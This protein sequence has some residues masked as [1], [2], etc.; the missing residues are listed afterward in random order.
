MIADAVD[1]HGAPGP[2]RAID[3]LRGRGDGVDA[4]AVLVGLQVGVLLVRIV[5][6]LNLRAGLL[7]AGLGPAVGAAAGHANIDAGVA[8]RRQLVLEAEIE[9]AILLLAP[10]PRPFLAGA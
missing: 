8:A 2:Q 10:Q 3:M 4:A 1:L 9:V 5:E 7:F 6:Q